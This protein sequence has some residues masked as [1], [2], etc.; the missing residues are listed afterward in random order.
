MFFLVR[1]EDKNF[2]YDL[3]EYSTIIFLKNLFY[4]IYDYIIKIFIYFYSIDFM[5]I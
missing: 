4:H 2:N 5:F 1:N 3:F